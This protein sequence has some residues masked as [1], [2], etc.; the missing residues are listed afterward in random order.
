MHKIDLNGILD[1]VNCE[2]SRRGLKNYVA[3]Y[4]M[5]RVEDNKL[6]I[7]YRCFVG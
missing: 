7:G 5:M 4:P 6:Y 2:K 1:I 3:C